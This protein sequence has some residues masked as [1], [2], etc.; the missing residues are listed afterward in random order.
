MIQPFLLSY[1][2]LCL[3]VLQVS[4]SLETLILYAIIIISDQISQVQKMST[5]F[6]FSF[7]FISWRLVTLQ[8]C[9]G[10]CHTLT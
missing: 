5:N 10:F 3:N 7:I 6:F 4:D 1:P 8:Y 9:S 2:S